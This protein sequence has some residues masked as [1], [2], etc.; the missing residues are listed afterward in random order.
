MEES[1]TYNG[2]QVTR[3]H[4]NV[5]P[6]SGR[7]GST[8]AQYQSR[9]EV[10]AQRHP[11]GNQRSV[12]RAQLQQLP[13]LWLPQAHRLI[14]VDVEVTQRSQHQVPGQGYPHD[15]RTQVDW[16]LSSV[17]SSPAFLRQDVWLWASSVA[18]KGN[19]DLDFQHSKEP[20][21]IKA[22]YRPCPVVFVLGRQNLLPLPPGRQLRR[23]HVQGRWRCREI[24]VDW[25]WTTHDPHA[26][27]VFQGVAWRRASLAEPWVHHSLENAG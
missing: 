20:P 16:Q 6:V 9:V 26:Y 12:L 17:Q 21:Q 5:P 14:F 2:F 4:C 13:I 11:P 3:Y 27:Q 15:L 19:D 25:N 1:P 10:G 7:Y 22:I 8:D 24:S 23:N 18:G